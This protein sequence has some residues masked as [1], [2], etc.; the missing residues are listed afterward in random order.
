ML[1]PFEA[2]VPQMPDL[3]CLSVWWSIVEHLFGE[4]IFMDRV[5]F[6]EVGPQG[7]AWRDRKT[8]PGTPAGV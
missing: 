3:K 2:G 1:R 4:M 7:L 8:V 6:R 5:R